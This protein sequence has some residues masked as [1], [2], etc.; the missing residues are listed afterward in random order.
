M[1]DGGFR[2]GLLAQLSD[3]RV[4]A[5]RRQDAAVDARLREFWL[6]L[7]RMLQVHS[8]APHATQYIN[9]LACLND[10]L[11]WRGISPVVRDIFGQGL[12]IMR[13]LMW[14]HTTPA[15]VYLLSIISDYGQRRV[16]D[17]DSHGI[18]STVELALLGTSCRR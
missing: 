5:R 1:A 6:L 7:T 11:A 18:Y 15:M 13:I 2:D 12:H 8:H 14:L 9:F 3:A 4:R 17:L 10:Y 16:R